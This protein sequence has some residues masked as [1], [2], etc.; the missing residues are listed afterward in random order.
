MNEILGVLIIFLIDILLCV[1]FIFPLLS[2]L[3]CGID[4]PF[5]EV[6]IDTQKHN[7]RVIRRLFINDLTVCPRCGHISVEHIPNEYD[8]CLQCTYYQPSDALIAKFKNQGK[9]E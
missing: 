2:Y 8:H 7:I 3:S 1:L 4:R 6:W 9:N 5:K